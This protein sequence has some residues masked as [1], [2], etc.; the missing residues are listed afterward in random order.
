M[1]LTIFI[2]DVPLV[3]TSSAASRSAVLVHRWAGQPNRSSSTARARTPGEDCR[4]AAARRCRTP[5][6]TNPADHRLPGCVRTSGPRRSDRLL[7]G[8]QRHQEAAQRKAPSASCSGRPSWADS[9]KVIVPCEFVAHGCQRGDA[10]GVV[11][12]Y[13]TPHPRQSS[14]A[15]TLASAGARCHRPLGCTPSAVSRRWRRPVRSN[16]PHRPGPRTRRWR[17]DPPRRSGGNVSSAGCP[18]PRCRHRARR[19]RGES[20]RRRQRSRGRRRCQAVMAG[21]SRK[22]QQRLAEDVELEL[23]VG[24]VAGDVDPPG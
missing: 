8:G 1:F 22:Q 18:A 17:A 7:M 21:G 14:A 15:S 4:G 19:Q 24:P 9:G 13:G 23:V 6:R 10:A 16:R 20:R 2:D 3:R 12:G 5:R 11:G